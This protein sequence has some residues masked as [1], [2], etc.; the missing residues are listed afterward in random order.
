MTAPKRSRGIR[1]TDSDWE[2]ITARA[3]A[4]GMRLSDYVIWQVLERPARVEAPAPT[5]LSDSV[6]GR[7]A[8]AVMVLFE[9][10]RRRVQETDQAVVW[11]AIAAEV[12]AW[13]ESEER[14]G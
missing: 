13:L 2:R 1:C 9:F 6:Q 7:M 11:D 3:R 8:K 4:A 10:E 12:D 5:P 14:L